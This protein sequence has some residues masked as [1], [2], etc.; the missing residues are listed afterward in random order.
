MMKWRWLLL[1]LLCSGTAAGAGDRPEDFA[2][3][4][5]VQT[6]AGEALQR[7]EIPQ[8]VYEGAARSDL[9]DVRVFNGAG[10]VVP[11]AVLPRPTAA[12]SE[13]AAIDLPYYPLRGTLKN[14]P[15]ALEVHVRQSRDG[16]ALDVVTAPAAAGVEVLGYLVDARSLKQPLRTLELDWKPLANG[17]SGTLR[18]EGSDDLSHWS[19][20][21][22]HAPLLGLEFAGQQLE[23]KTIR[24]QG[25][26]YRYLRLSWPPGQPALDLTRLAGRPGGDRIDPERRWKDVTGTAGEKPGEYLFD[27][28]GRLPVDRLRIQLPEP[29]TLVSVQ[30]LAR[31]APEHPW[32][33]IASGVLYRLQ[34]DGREIS[35]P[36]LAVAVNG[37]RYWM[38]RVDQKGGGL[39]H[40][41]PQLAAGWVPQQMVFVARGDPPFAL[42][43]GNARA[44]PSAYSVEMV[45]PGW[46]PNEPFTAGAASTGPQRVVAGATALRPGFDY[47]T[48]LL[49]GSLVLGVMVLAWMAWQLT[50]QMK[51]EQ[52]AASE[53]ARGETGAP[54]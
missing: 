35:S 36:D 43:Y 40:G 15:N 22:D 32:Q 4:V 30:A 21:A 7:V 28:G 42:A 20:L 24:L 45:V 26:A 48:W 50:R 52:P 16:T 9:G 23:Q 18:V 14:R 31:S 29:N 2:Y 8:S 44:Q 11:Y 25:P 37:W 39:G 1:A 47:K 6:G 3:A 27:L 12:I 10:E 33:P 19:P 51:A 41:V 38:L 49:W 17:F 46:Q 53:P 34:R 13:A 5:T 54:K